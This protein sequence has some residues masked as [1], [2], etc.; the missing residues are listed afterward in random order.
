MTACSTDGFTSERSDK[1][2]IMSKPPDLHW[3]HDLVGDGKSAKV[4]RPLVGR[5]KA[6]RSQTHYKKTPSGAE[7][8]ATVAAP[9]GNPSTSSSS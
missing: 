6:G 8:R 9:N 5:K 1:S 7:R 3:L 2:A 4:P